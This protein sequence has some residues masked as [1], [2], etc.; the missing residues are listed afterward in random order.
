M[1]QICKCGHDKYDHK[2]YDGT[3]TCLIRPVY[4]LCAC[5]KFK[6][7]KGNKLK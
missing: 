3:G 7:M 5:L 6:Q 4:F 1:K 2:F